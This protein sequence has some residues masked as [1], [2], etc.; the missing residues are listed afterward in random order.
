MFNRVEYLIK[1]KWGALIHRHM[2]RTACCRTRSRIRRWTPSR[3]T[4]STFA[5]KRLAQQV[6]VARRRGQTN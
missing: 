5:A 2:T 3:V 4:T 6:A 1:G